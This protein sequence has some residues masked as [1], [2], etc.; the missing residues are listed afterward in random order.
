M[1]LFLGKNLSKFLTHVSKL[2]NP[3]CHTNNYW[4]IRNL[5][6]FRKK[7]YTSVFSY[8]RIFHF[9]QPLNEWVGNECFSSLCYISNLCTYLYFYKG[10][11]K[12]LSLLSVPKRISWHRMNLFP[13]LYNSWIY[14]YKY[15]YKVISIFKPSLTFYFTYNRGNSRMK[16][17][18]NEILTK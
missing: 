18:E 6:K 17:Y 11:S 13:V 10:I 15:I 4:W 2:H 1:C 9:F 8:L 12:T 7:G 3:Y 16:L 14:I 5:C